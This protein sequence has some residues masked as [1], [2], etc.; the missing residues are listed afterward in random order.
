MLLIIFLGLIV[1]LTSGSGDCEIGTQEVKLFDYYKVCIGVMT[2]FLKK[3]ACKSAGSILYFIFISIKNYS[4]V[5][6]KSYLI[7]YE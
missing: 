6:N 3:A 4:I 1:E 2:G 7:V 5:Y